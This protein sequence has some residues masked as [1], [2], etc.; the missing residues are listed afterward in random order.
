MGR[1]GVAAVDGAGAP[2]PP[3]FA[4]FHAGE[5]RLTHSAANFVNFGP[6]GGMGRA[7]LPPSAFP[8]REERE[9]ISENVAL[10]T[11]AGSLR[12]PV[13]HRHS[14]SRLNIGSGMARM[15]SMSKRQSR[16]T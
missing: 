13:R 14:R 7:F 1:A 3:T 8:V 6:E 5:R 4:G 12:S 2:V 9:P 10:S 16:Y 15:I 11:L